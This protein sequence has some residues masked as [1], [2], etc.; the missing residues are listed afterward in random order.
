MAGKG[1]IL[2]ARAK[3]TV[4]RAQAIHAL[5]LVKAGNSWREAARIS[6]YSDVSNCHRAVKKLMDKR[7][8]ESVDELRALE[9]ER[10]DELALSVWDAARAGNW[11]AME[12]ALRI[13]ERRA[14]LNGLDAPTRSELSGP[15]GAALAVTLIMDR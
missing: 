9:N 3:N 6:G 11:K 13:M 8:V 10:L 5:E 1:G 7:M 4:F 12:N 15:E 14:K 2:G